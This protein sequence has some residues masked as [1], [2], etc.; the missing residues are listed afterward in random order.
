LLAKHRQEG[1]KERDDETGEE[2]GLDVD[3]RARRSWPLRESGDVVSECSVVE[4]VNED[5]DKGG[6]LVV[7]IGL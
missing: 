6:G 4:L 1:R 2:D 7:R 5:T 3:Y